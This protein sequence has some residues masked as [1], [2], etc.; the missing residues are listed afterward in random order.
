[1][2]RTRSNHL[3]PFDVLAVNS[4]PGAL[5]VP[6]IAKVLRSTASNV[7]PYNVP[8]L[9]NRQPAHSL[10]D[11]V[12]VSCSSSIEL[13]LGELT[14]RVGEDF[15]IGDV[16][17]EFDSTLRQIP[18][19]RGLGQSVFQCLVQFRTVVVRRPCMTPTKHFMWS[20]VAMLCGVPR[21]IS[22]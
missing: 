8:P 3:G 19:P 9:C 20:C 14:F 5:L 2:S 1:T 4:L 12:Q 6:P 16:T 17:P 18:V 10:P 15:G 22:T 21:T 7:C 13:V 11:P